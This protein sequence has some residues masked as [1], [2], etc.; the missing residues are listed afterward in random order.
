MNN[1]NER[2]WYVYILRCSDGKLYTGCTSNLKNR[3]FAHSHGNVKSTKPRLPI[4]LISTTAFT[5]KHKAF[6]F[7][8][9]LKSGSGRAF[10]GKHL[11]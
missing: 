4:K 9:Y 1:P 10:A 8:K 7:E 5:E 2:Y 6:L 3:L 11:F